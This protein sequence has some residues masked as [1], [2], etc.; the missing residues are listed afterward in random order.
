[1]LQAYTIKMSGKHTLPLQWHAALALSPEKTKAEIKH[2]NHYRKLSVS[3]NNSSLGTPRAGIETWSRQH[4][5]GLSCARFLESLAISWVGGN[6]TAPGCTFALR[7]A[8]AI[9][10]R[11]AS[12]RH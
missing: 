5:R 8:K 6:E 10:R 1:M 3:C 11:R 9:D 4:G 2:Q 7:R 12:A